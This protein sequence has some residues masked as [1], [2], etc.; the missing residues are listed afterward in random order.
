MKYFPTIITSLASIFLL[1]ACNSHSDMATDYVEGMETHGIESAPA[2]H[3]GPSIQWSIDLV[4]DYIAKN[5]NKPVQANPEEMT[6]DD[7]SQYNSDYYTHFYGIYHTFYSNYTWQTIAD[8]GSI[9]SLRYYHPEILAVKPIQKIKDKNGKTIFISEIWGFDAYSKN[10]SNG[11]IDDCGCV[12]NSDLFVSPI[13]TKV[14]LDRNDMAD[15]VNAVQHVQNK[16]KGYSIQGYGIVGNVLEN[17]QADDV[18]MA[19][20]KT[21]EGK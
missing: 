3:A 8:D 6:R 21:K 20:A 15:M 19:I 12:S 11:A 16:M 9:K 17:N 5:G 4:D 13:H 7:F 1:S 14:A 2:L 18:K 10:R